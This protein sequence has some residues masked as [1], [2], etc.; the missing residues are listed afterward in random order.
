MAKKIAKSRLEAAETVRLI[1]D[2]L[3][4]DKEFRNLIGGIL[5]SI[6]LDTK[7]VDTKSIKEINKSYPDEEAIDEVVKDFKQLLKDDHDA[8]IV[9]VME[10]IA[11]II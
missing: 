2:K 10:S 1:S 3:F 5:Y 11:N 7:I 9:L 8:C 6:C 4:A